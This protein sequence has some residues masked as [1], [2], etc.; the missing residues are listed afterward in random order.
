MSNRFRSSL[1]SGSFA[2][3]GL[4]TSGT[5]VI[6]TDRATDGIRSLFVN[7]LSRF[8]AFPTGTANARRY[9]VAARV[10]V[11]VEPSAVTTVMGF[12]NAGTIDR[13]RIRYDPSTNNFGMWDS[14][15]QVGSASSAVNLGEWNSIELQAMIDTGA[16][17]VDE[18]AARLNGTIFASES[19]DKYTVVT[20]DDINR[21]WWGHGGGVTPGNFYFDELG[22]NDDQGASDTTWVFSSVANP[23]YAPA[24]MFDPE[25]NSRAWF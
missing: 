2:T 21:A 4:T 8:A 12:W 19:V 5:P 14:T 16:G 7:G 23:S 15:A 13:W 17:Q 9:Y 22:V 3:E 18:A 24:G 6:S 25:L 20:T 10:W 1:E 11:D